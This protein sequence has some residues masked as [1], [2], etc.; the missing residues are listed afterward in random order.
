[1]I[2]SHHTLCTTPTPPRKHPTVHIKDKPETKRE[3]E[4]EYLRIRFPDHPV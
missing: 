3:E 4:K 2:V 1:M